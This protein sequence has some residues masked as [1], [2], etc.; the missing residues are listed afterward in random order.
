MK[1]AVPGLYS[2][3]FYSVEIEVPAAWC[4]YPRVWVD[5]A[6]RPAELVRPRTLRVHVEVGE[7]V[8]LAFR[9]AA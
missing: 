2:T 1:L 6:V 9:G 5:G 4:R 8:E 3:Y 7:G